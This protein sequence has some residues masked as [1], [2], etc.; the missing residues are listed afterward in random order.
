M[1]NEPRLSKAY[2]IVS[3]FHVNITPVSS[4]SIQSAIINA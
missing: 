4:L 1:S 3:Y 2:G